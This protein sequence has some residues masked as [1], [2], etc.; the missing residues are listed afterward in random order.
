M[1]KLI[2]CFSYV[3]DHKEAQEIVIDLDSGTE[4]YSVINELDYNFNDTT[5]NATIL[6]SSIEDYSVEDSE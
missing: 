2:N 5:G 4:L 6:D 1:A 3:H